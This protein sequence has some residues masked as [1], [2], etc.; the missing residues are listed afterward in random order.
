MNDV[1]Q[2]LITRMASLAEPTRIRMLHLLQRDALLVSDLAD[3]LQ[4]PQSTVSRHLKQLSQQGWLVSRRDGTSHEYRMIEVEL[5]E[6]ARALWQIVLT[7]TLDQPAIAQDR[8]RLASVRASRERDSRSFFAGAARDW[9]QLR[10]DLFGTHFSFQAMLSLL[11]HSLVVAD[12][13]CGTGALVQEL[14]QHVARVIGVDNSPPML[15]AAARRV[16]GLKNVELRTGDLTAVPIDSKT[17]DGALMVLSLSYA[18]DIAVALAEARRVLKLEGR[19]I[20]LDVLTHDR[21]DFRRQMGQT[22]MGFSPDELTRDLNAAGFSDI[23]VRTLAPQPQVKGPALVL[24]TASRA[25]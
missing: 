14:S 10:S 24:A 11:D 8:L 6:P 9:D 12:L 5:S 18:S 21:D 17:I 3:V 4:L 19:L 16:S 1:T 22:R 23:R 15:E 13:G 7:Q 2:Q 20:V 25:S